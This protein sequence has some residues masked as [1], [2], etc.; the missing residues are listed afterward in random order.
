MSLATGDEDA[1]RRVLDDYLESWNRCDAKACAELY[2]RTGDLLAVDGTFLR[3]HAQIKQYYDDNLSGKYAGFQARS[4][5]VLGVREVGAEVALLDAIWEV[6]A[7]SASDAPS[8]PIAK[9]IGSFVLVKSNDAWKISAARLM[10]PFK[11]S[12]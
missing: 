9:P 10:V 12:Q 2:D 3:S 5:E 6:H 11:V 8:K 4:V 1:I 7:P